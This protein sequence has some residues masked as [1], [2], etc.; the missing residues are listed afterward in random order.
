MALDP[1]QQPTPTA[2]QRAA[3]QQVHA[4]LNEAYRQITEVVPRCAERTLAMRKLEE[5]DMWAAKAIV[6]DGQVY[7]SQEGGTGLVS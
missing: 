4:A 7:L 1:F 3:I 5:A 6:F 2:A